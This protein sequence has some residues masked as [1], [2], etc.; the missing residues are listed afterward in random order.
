MTTL[1]HLLLIF[2]LALFV[3]CPTAG[4][5]DD[6]SSTG[7]DDDAT[8]DDD[9]A[10]GDDDDATG[11]DDDS[12]GDDDDDPTGSCRFLVGT[13]L[14]ACQPSDELECEA[15]DAP[16]EVTVEWL[17]QPCPG[18]EAASCATDEPGAIDWY[19]YLDQTSELYDPWCE[20]CG[21]D[22]E[23]ADYCDNASS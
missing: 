5:D 3:G 15:G 8:G 1:R 7:D 9:D 23:P 16:K 21:S 6:D 17:A 11:D 2:C 12:K 13:T 20:S 18:G 10:T 19:Y 14:A 4:G 22:L